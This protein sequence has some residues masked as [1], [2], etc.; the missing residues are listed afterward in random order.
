[1]C[2]RNRRTQVAGSRAG[3]GTTRSEASPG[4]SGKDESA[5]AVSH[6]VASTV[7]YHS[8]PAA[9][10]FPSALSSFSFSSARATPDL[11]PQHLPCLF[12]FSILEQ[13]VQ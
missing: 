4:N 12:C 3:C 7:C 8:V 5:D 1:M 10:T 2:E 11:L 6:I 9:R 13:C